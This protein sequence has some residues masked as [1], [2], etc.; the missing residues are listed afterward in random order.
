MTRDGDKLVGVGSGGKM[1]MSLEVVNGELVE[2][3]EA[4]EQKLTMKRFHTKA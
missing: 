1:K 3:V 2:T 4:V